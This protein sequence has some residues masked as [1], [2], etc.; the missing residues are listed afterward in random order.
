MKTVLITGANRGIGL[1]FA[2]QYA[3]A[4][5]K[6]LAC[7][8]KLDYGDGLSGLVAE[9]PSQVLPYELDVANHEQIDRFSDMLSNVSID[10]LINNAGIYPKSGA[11]EFGGID[12]DAWADSF[13]VNT[14]AP[15][16]LVESFSPQITCSELKTIVTITSK[17]GSVTDNKSGGSYIYRSSKSAVNIVMKS[18]ALDLKSFGITAVL[19]HPG[20]VK[21]DMGGAGGLITAEQSVTGMRKVIDQ[22]T[23]EDSGCF[24][25]FDG[26]VVP[27]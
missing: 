23:P 20:W 12:Y 9:Y 3:N 14:M 4:G 27:W 21:T 7:T 24:Y 6:V 1:A 17:M 2:Q 8:R 26:Q 15:L 10:L 18:L 19:L 13:R 22:L 16:K 5:W 11:G 25:T